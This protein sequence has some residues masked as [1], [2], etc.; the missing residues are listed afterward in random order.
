M[1]AHTVTAVVDVI[2]VGN[3]KMVILEATGSPSYDSG[4]SVL[5]LSTSEATLGT[6][7]GFAKVYT[8]SMQ[9]VAAASSKYDCVY[10]PAASYAPATGL[11]KIHDT[12]QAADAEASGNLSGV[13]FRFLVVGR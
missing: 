2:P 9:A 11:V 1:S 6:W 12:S 13:T 8:C 3:A 5:D 10:V 7:A 4:G